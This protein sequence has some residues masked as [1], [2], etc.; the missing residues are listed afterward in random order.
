MP[1]LDGPP[2][3]LS[4]LIEV[5]D[6]HAVEYLIVGGAAAFAYGAER[7]TDDADCVVR[8][9]RANLERLAGALRELNAR[10]RVGGM[11]DAEAKMLPVQNR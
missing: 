8:R 1:G 7:P 11:S 4:R 5:L 6:R 10:L 2:L 9:G 3:D